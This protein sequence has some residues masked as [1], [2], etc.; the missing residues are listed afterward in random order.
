M[1]AVRLRIHLPLRF[2][3]IRHWPTG[4]CQQSVY[5]AY[6]LSPGIMK[7]IIYLSYVVLLWNELTFF[8]AP[9]CSASFPGN[10]PSR[11]GKVDVPAGIKELRDTQ[12]MTM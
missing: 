3:Y 4:Q 5:P 10:C 2:L 12:R 6:C 7:H 1:F 9:V 11:Y 8:G